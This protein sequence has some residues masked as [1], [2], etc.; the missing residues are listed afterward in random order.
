MGKGITFFLGAN[1]GGGFASLYDQLLDHGFSDLAII[2]GGPGCGKS[3]LMRAVAAAAEAQGREVHYIRCSGDPD[4]LDGVILPDVNK[5][6]VDGTAPHVLEPR[7][8]AV[9]ERYLDLSPFYDLALV[10]AERGAIVRAC[11]A[12][13]D[14]YASAYRVLRAVEAV[15]SERRGMMHAAMDFDHLRRRAE[16]IAAR[17]LAGKKCGGGSE[18]SVFF[19]GFTCKGEITYIADAVRD[20]PRVYELSDSA[21]LAAP[22]LELLKERALAVGERVLVGRD[23]LHPAAP[24]HLLIPARGLA[25]VTGEH[26]AESYRRVRLDAMAEGELSRGEKARLRLLRRLRR[27]LAEEAVE[28]L[29]TA[30][31]AHDELERLYHPYVDFDAVSALAAREAE[32]A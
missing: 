21:Q 31:A 13:R 26:S 28:Q 16:G 4:S 23:A 24:L 22:M 2:K 1:S 3:S 25:F 32:R 27:S 15:E 5:A 6:Y 14:A 29:K 17:E 20:Y 9:H 10:K 18:A 12:Y 30:K 11:D 7:Y 19:C 8:T